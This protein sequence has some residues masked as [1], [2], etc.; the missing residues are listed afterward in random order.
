[1]TTTRFFH[2]TIRG[3]HSSLP[4]AA[5]VPQGSL[6]SCTDH[7]LVYK[8]TEAQ[9]GWETWLETGA[10]GGG[11]ADEVTYDNS[12][13]ALIATDVQAAIDEVED[14]VDTLELGGGGGASASPASKVYAY[15]TFR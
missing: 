5:T 1:M 4:D 14:R 10:G 7:G 2:H 13:S 15:T 9:D 8:T 12:A 3:D 11:D 6:Y